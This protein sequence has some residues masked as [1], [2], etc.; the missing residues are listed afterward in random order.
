MMAVSSADVAEEDLSLTVSAVARRMGVAPAT[1]RTWDRRYGVGPSHHT[2]GSH[3]RYTASDMARLEHMRRLVIAGVTP[4]QAAKAAL[5]DATL[6]AG[7]ARVV[8]PDDG[9]RAGGGNVIALP[10]GGPLVRGLARAA[11]SLDTQASQQILTQALEELGVV[12]AWSDVIVPVLVAVGEKWRDSGR[13]VEVEHALS[14]SVRDVLGGFVRDCAPPSDGRPVLLA[15]APGDQHSLPLWAVCA[16]LAEQGIA[17]RVLGA[18]LPVHALASSMSKLGPAA[19]LIWSQ[20]T[21]TGDVASLA[22]LP[23]TR[24]AAA[25]LIAGPGWC[26]DESDENSA[27][28]P[29]RSLEEAVERIGRA[30]GR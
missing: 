29:V 7:G 4:A 26:I 13:G 21:D 24:P 25:I 12:A 16:A 22:E 27:A 8:T 6:P 19:V 17:A 14:A 30:L 23:V 28:V 5:A 9:G 10:G 11:Q 20:V 1:L 2:P 3:R 15:C 18:D